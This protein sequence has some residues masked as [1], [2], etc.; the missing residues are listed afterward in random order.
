MVI[1]PVD[2]KEHKAEHIAEYDGGEGEKIRH[3]GF[4]GDLQLENHDRDDDRHYAIAERF[5]SPL[6]HSSILPM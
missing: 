4:L 2:A 3:I 5:Q 6:A 1:V